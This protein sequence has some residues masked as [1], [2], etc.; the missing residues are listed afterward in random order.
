MQDLAAAQADFLQT[1]DLAVIRIGETGL[2]LLRFGSGEARLTGALRTDGILRGLGGLY[3]GQFTTGQRDAIPSGS[4]PTGLIV[5]NLTTAR[6][7]F[8]FG[9]DSVPNW[10]VLGADPA[11]VIA[12]SLASAKGDIIVA[13]AASVFDVLHLGSN[14]KVVRADSTQSLGVKWD[15]PLILDVFSARPAASSNAGVFFFAT[16]RGSLE[17]SNG[18]TWTLVASAPTSTTVTT[19]PPSPYDGQQVIFKAAPA[20]YWQLMWIASEAKW[21]FLGGAPLFSFVGNSEGIASDS[22]WHGTG[23]PFVTVPWNGFYRVDIGFTGAT[24]VPNGHLQMSYKIGATSPSGNDA[25]DG[26]SRSGSQ[27]AVFGSREKTLTTGTVLEAKYQTTESDAIG[28]QVYN[29]QITLNP[30]Y[31]TA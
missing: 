12:N 23:G 15:F 4:R 24:Q 9:S 10:K 28:S 18:S 13:S 30:V 26:V 19:L 29:R 11:S 7:E 3:A 2:S 8:N 17:Y 27:A 25:I 22:S 14:G 6:Y 16:D 1:I 5:Y 31:L 21:E 20:H